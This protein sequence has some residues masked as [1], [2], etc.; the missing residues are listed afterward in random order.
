MAIACDSQSLTDAGHDYCC[1]PAGVHPEVI[2]YLLNVISGLNLSPQD[3]MANAATYRVIPPGMQE[4]VMLYL[5][6]QISDAV[7]A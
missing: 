7:G 3:L 5:L 2:I 1:I 6:C 4:P